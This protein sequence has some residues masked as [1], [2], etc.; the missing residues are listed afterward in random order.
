MY[1]GKLIDSLGYRFKDLD[2]STNSPDKRAMAG[3]YVNQSTKWIYESFNWEQRRK[4]GE[5]VLVPNYTTG[6]CSFTLFDGT[7]EA[8]SRTVTFSQ[9]LPS[10]IA[11]RFLQIDGESDW[12]RIL[13]TNGTTAYLES[14][15]LSA[16]GSSFTI[17]K[18]FY[19]LPSNVDIVT[20]VG[21]WDGSGKLTYHTPEA[22]D[23]MVVNVS[24]SGTPSDFT[25]FGTDEFL[26]P[27][28]TGTITIESGSNVV[29][30]SGTSFIGNVSIGDI[31]TVNNVDYRVKRVESDTRLVLHNYLSTG[32][33]SSPYSAKKE[34]SLGLQLFPNG[35]DYKIIPYTYM[36]KQF[37]MIHETLERPNLPDRFDE[38]ILTRAEMMILKDQKNSQWVAVSQLLANQLEELKSKKKV[39]QTKF[40]QFPTKIYSWMPGRDI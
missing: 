8:A 22:L 3:F 19:Y 38:A 9:A 16:S 28:S 1:F 40:D 30:G 7:N 17:W 14:P 36:D 33:S 26:T 11:G 20:G 31:F 5:L 34:V 12:H 39:V 6:T 2:I 4:H 21:K 13:Y 24:E 32:V 23:D 29:T 15:V 10:G 37:D 35:N 27:Y 25:P 18:R